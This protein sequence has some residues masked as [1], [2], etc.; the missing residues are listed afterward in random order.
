MVSHT[1]KGN[2]SH[3]GY[4]AGVHRGVWHVRRLGATHC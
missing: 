2:C 1:E 4:G 3:S